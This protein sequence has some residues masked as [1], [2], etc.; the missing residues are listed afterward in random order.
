MIVV[1]RVSLIALTQNSLFY[2][3]KLDY[4]VAKVPKVVDEVTKTGLA[5]LPQNCFALQCLSYYHSRESW[6]IRCC[7]SRTK[8]ILTMSER[9][10]QPLQFFVQYAN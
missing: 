2:Y 1:L 10:H 8:P 5:G 3:S 6:I 4:T 9:F 7:V